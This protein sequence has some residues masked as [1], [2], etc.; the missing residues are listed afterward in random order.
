MQGTSSETA[1]LEIPDTCVKTVP[2]STVKE[3]P[4]IIQRIKEASREEAITSTQQFFATVDQRNTGISTRGPIVVPAEVH[5]RD[6]I[7][8]PN[9]PASTAVTTPDVLDVE[10]RGT[11]NPRISLPKGSPSQPT[12]T[13]TCRPRTWMQQITEGQ[14]NEP[15]REDASSSESNTFEIETLPKEIHDELGCEWRVLH[16]F[17]LPG[18]RFP[19]DSTPPNQR[20]LAENDALVELIQT[21][22]Y[23]DDVPTWGQRDYRLYPPSI[24]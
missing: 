14:I 3:A 16:P 2:E 19:M 22:E 5:E 18:V 7:E 17:E 6:V 9:A 15:R 20:R 21:T 23:L 8:T 11:S 1:Y 13:A 4:R 24:W 12:V 10:P